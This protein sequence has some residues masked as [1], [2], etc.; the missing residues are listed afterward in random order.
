MCPAPTSAWRTEYDL[1][2]A[3]SEGIC[4]F[5][6]RRRDLIVSHIVPAFVIRHQKATSGGPHLVLRSG[7]EPPKIVQDGHKVPFLCFDCDSRTLGRW[8]GEFAR[9]FFRKHLAHGPAGVPYG[10]WLQKFCAVVCWRALAFMREEGGPPNFTIE[11]IV[12]A[13]QAL[14]VWRDVIVDRRRMATPHEV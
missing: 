7:A 4:R 2:E 13:E 1:G 9:R 12:E 5:C 10:P 8:E 14:G 3:M 11:Q 6:G